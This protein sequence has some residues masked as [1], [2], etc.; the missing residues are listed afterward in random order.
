MKILKPLKITAKTPIMELKG[1]KTK[2]RIFIK[3]DD[4]N[5]LLISGN[6]ARKLEYLIA[7]AKRQKCDTIITCGP[8]QSN[9]CRTTAAFAQ[10]FGLDC[11]LLL[12]VHKKPSKVYMGN[13]LIDKLLGAKICYITPGQY[14]RRIDVM[15]EYAKKLKK[16]GKRS[17]II[18][19]GGSNEI[20]ALGYLDCMKEMVDFIRK[21]KIEAIYCAVGSGG[22]YAGL[23]IGKKLYRLAIDLNGVIVCDTIVYFKEKIYEICRDAIKKFNFPIKIVQKDINLIDGYI[24]KGYGVPYPEELKTIRRIARLGIILEPVYT[25]KAFYGMLNHLKRHRYKKVIFIHT[26]GIYSIFAFGKEITDTFH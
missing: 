20:G 25:G 3:R 24:G 23:V 6:K 22:T 4:L 8:L 21:E 16:R 17:Y 26:G 12:R 7:D 11:H 13:L 1:L 5:G 10:H 18:P 15:A 14:Q 2:T 19:E 9:H